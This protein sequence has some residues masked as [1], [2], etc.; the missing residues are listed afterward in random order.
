MDIADADGC[1]HFFTNG[2]FMR[3]CEALNTGQEEFAVLDGLLEG[4]IGECDRKFLTTI[5]M[6]FDCFGFETIEHLADPSQC[7]NVTLRTPE[8][9]RLLLSILHINSTGVYLSMTVGR[10]L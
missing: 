10:T 7:F 5:P 9:Q 3:Q 2:F 8:H 6:T 1:R 4:A